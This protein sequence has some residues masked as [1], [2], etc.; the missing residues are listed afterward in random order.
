MSV[1]LIFVPTCNA[2]CTV[3]CACMQLAADAASWCR[4]VQRSFQSS[5]A[6][7]SVSLTMFL[8]S[9]KVSSVILPYPYFKRVSSDEIVH[10]IVLKERAK[11][12]FVVDDGA[13]LC[14]PGGL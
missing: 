5:E 3:N 4:V 2:F 11:Y 14:Q 12:N 10:S 13:T 7:D 8:R 9:A 1:A 6:V